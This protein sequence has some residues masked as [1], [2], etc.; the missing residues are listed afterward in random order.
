M[1]IAPE[2]PLSP[3]GLALIEGSERALRQFYTVEESFAYSPQELA[4]PGVTF[5]VARDGGTPLGCVASAD[6]G[7][8]VEVKR[9]F[10]TPATQG[11]GV[12]RALMEHLEGA[13]RDAGHSLARLETGD[14]LVA[15]CALY[16]QMGY[17]RRAPF[18]DY[19]DVPTST[20]MEKPL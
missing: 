15:A 3:D 18:A 7:D 12:G 19:P 13:A 16:A 4:A 11:K 9:L 6:M 2:D 14:L 17:T 20:F 10:V 8:Y 5:F 1:K